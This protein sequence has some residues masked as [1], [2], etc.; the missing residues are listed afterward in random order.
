MGTF[1]LSLPGEKWEKLLLELLVVFLGVSAGFLLNNWRIDQEEQELKQEYLQSIGGDVNENILLLEGVIQDD[2]LLLERMSP[3][4]A[5][6]KSKTLP[7]DSAMVCIQLILAL[8][9]V[10]LNSNSYLNIMNSGSLNLIDEFELKSQVV[11]YFSAIRGVN[12]V[13]DYFYSYFNEFVMPF[14]ISE[15]D[16]VNQQMV[17]P[18]AVHSVHF[19]NVLTGYFAMVQQRK[20]AYRGFLEKSLSLDELLTDFQQ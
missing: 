9:R 10:D 20:E 2:E 4:L 5:E 17:N 16:L 12:F 8:S 7:A 18:H 15:V 6:L 3:K 1:K 13:D 14:I 11:S 19:S